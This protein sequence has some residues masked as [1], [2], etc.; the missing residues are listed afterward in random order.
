MRAGWALTKKSWQVIR[1]NPGLMRLPVIGGLLGSVLFIVFGG[2]GLFLL[3]QE[4]PTTSEN[5][6][7]G[8]LVVVGVYLS[9]FTVIYFNVALAACAQ[10]ALK[11]EQ[12]SIGGG[13]AVSRSRLGAIAAWAAV[14]ALISIIFSVIRDRGGLAGQIGAAALATIWSLITFLVVPVLAFEGIGPVA[15]IKRSAGLFRERW[16]QQITGNIAIGGIAGLFF[17]LGVVAAVAGGFLIA[18]GGTAGEAGGA[19]LVLVGV[20]IAIFA[21]VMAGAMRGVFGV[22][23]YNYVAEDKA[24]EPFTEADLESAVRVK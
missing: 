20:V 14:S 3:A 16:G 23:L 1:S 8:A 2:P 13:L 9:S 21:A 17:L 10:S 19:A 15:A 18:S 4:S 24:L 6:A 22:A 7:G 5:V 11:G 12:Y